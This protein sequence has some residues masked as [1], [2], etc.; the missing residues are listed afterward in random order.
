VYG[1]DGVTPLQPTEWVKNLKKSAGHLFQGFQGGGAGG[2]NQGP[3]GKDLSQMSATEKISMGLKMA[4]AE[5]AHR[6]P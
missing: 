6:A 4:A 2:G 5:S 1:A 3:G